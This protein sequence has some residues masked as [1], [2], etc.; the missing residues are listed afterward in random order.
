MGKI[1]TLLVLFFIAGQCYAQSFI[2]KIDG[3][4]IDVAEGAIRVDA[5]NKRLIYTPYGKEQAKLKFKEIDSAQIGTSLFKVF[6]IGRKERG[7]YVL[8]K[9][10]GKSL[11]TISTVKTRPA[12]G[13]ESKYMRFEMVIVDSNKKYCTKLH[14]P[15]NPTAITRRAD[16]RPL[17]RLNSISS[18]VPRFWSVF[19]HLNW[20][21]PMRVMPSLNF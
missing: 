16:L 17:R 3:S 13:Y 21:K 11:L 10:D 18:N 15:M 5:N 9:V 20:Q 1:K 19:L 4:R 7:Y 8:A 2:Q 6:K 12:G 14:S